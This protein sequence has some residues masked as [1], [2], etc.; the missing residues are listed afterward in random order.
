MGEKMKKSKLGATACALLAA[1]LTIVG[2]RGAFVEYSTININ[3]ENFECFISE[4]SLNTSLAQPSKADEFKSVSSDLL[5]GSE[6]ILLKTVENNPICNSDTKDASTS[7]SSINANNHLH[8]DNKLEENTESN[9]PLPSPEPRAEKATSALSENVKVSSR[10]YE[11]L[12]GS[13]SSATPRTVGLGGSVFG[14]K[15]QQSEVTVQDS[16]GVP[17]LSKGDVIHSINGIPVTT[18]KEAAR[19]ISESGG[20]SITIKASRRGVPINL[21]LRPQKADGTW[22]LGLTLRDGAMGIGTMTFYDPGTGLFGGLGHGICTSEGADPVEMKSGE[23]TGALLGGIRRGESGKPGELSGILTGEKRG[24]LTSNN[25]CGVYGY[26][27]GVPTPERL[28]EV[29]TK[30]QLHEGE[31]TVV[32][33]LKN[34]KSAE[35]KIKIYDIDKTASGSKCFRIKV[36]DDVLIA[37][38]GGIVR[39]MSGSP[40]IQD[41]KLVGAVTHVMVADPTEGYGIFIENMLNAVQN[42]TIPKAA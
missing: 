9:D 33:T 34:G 40:I 4:S 17:A 41:G 37:L 14:I 18:V 10:I 29:G 6:D 2:A 36:T 21:E 24:T 22:S 7:K 20:S 3:E 13:P 19:L 11:L 39:G 35:Y 27:D 16:K 15:I 26:L 28:V 8:S 32:S 31:A 38:T 12:F 5:P 23:V 25:E 42:Q 1:C 30:N